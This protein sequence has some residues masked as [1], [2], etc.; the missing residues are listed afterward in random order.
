MPRIKSKGSGISFNDLQKQP[1]LSPHIKNWERHLNNFLTLEHF[2]PLR[3]QKKITL[4]NMFGGLAIYR[5]DWL[6]LIIM[7]SPEDFQYKDKK[8]DFPIWDGILLVT[9]HCHHSALKAR[10]PELINHP[11]LPKWLYLRRTEQDFEKICKDLS[12]LI[13]NN[14]PL[15]G[16][17]PKKNKNKRKKH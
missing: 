5:K 17:P 16:I 13:A 7:E 15:I 4:K 2:L 1:E 14:F 9:D 6:C 11:I 8:V 10:Y 3:S 12:Q